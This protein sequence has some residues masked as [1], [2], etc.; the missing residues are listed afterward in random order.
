MEKKKLTYVDALVKLG[1][2]QAEAIM[3][4]RRAD[5]QTAESQQT[6]I[7]QAETDGEAAVMVAAPISVP[8][9]DINDFDDNWTKLLTIIDASDSKVSVIDGQGQCNRWA[10]SV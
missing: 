9:V 5:I 3:E 6:D 8:H 4:K 1:C 10:R 2:A 7:Q